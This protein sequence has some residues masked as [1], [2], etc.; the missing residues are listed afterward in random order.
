MQRITRIKK[1]MTQM[2]CKF[3]GGGGVTPHNSE[4]G[5][6]TLIS[7]PDR[8]RPKISDADPQH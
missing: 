7:V 6:E 1:N 3:G 5:Y 4:T 8:I 2:S